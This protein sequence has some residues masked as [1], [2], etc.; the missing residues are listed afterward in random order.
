MH[1]I[2]ETLVCHRVFLNHTSSHHLITDMSLF[3][4]FTPIEPRRVITASGAML[5]AIAVGTVEFTTFSNGCPFPIKISEAM[6]VPFMS[7]S[8]LSVPQMLKR[9]FKVCLSA[10]SCSISQLDDCIALTC[11]KTN[12]LYEMPLV[13]YHSHSATQPHHHTVERSL[14]EQSH[15]T[16]DVHSSVTHQEHAPK[17]HHLSHKNHSRHSIDRA[18]SWRSSRS[19][20]SSTCPSLD[21]KLIERSSFKYVNSDMIPSST[22][23][24]LHDSTNIELINPVGIILCQLPDPCDL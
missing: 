6:Y 1:V 15:N 23:N 4:K 14:V 5:Y 9:D 13:P 16:T 17:L 19:H 18:T 12:S 24:D 11:S 21:D 8:V 3:T 7:H 20:S 10:T 2:N 22:S